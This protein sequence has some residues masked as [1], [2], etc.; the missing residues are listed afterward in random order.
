MKPVICPLCKKEFEGIEADY[1]SQW[2]IC[3]GCE[4]RTWDARD[5][6]AE[7]RREDDE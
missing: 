7:E 6:L 5:F 1:I 2:D 4:K 3:L